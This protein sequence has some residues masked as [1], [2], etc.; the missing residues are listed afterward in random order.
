[1]SSVIIPNGNPS[2]EYRLVKGFER[3]AVGNDGSVWSRCKQ[4]GSRKTKTLKVA[5]EWKRLR[6]W[7]RKDGYK[8][9]AFYSPIRKKA[10]VHHLVLEAFVG[11]CPDGMEGC[12]FPD[13]NPSNNRLDNLRW[14]TS[15]ANGQDMVSHGTS[16]RG[17]RNPVHKLTEETVLL[18]LKLLRHGTSQDDVARTLGV[19]QAT[20]SMIFRGHRWAWLTQK[21]TGAT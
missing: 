19:S 16:T 4:G 11:A 6:V 21:S 5:N 3:Y 9:I 13:R 2:V 10:Y 12:H 1:M 7:T 18:A 15:K 14:D 20:I 17:S 8:V